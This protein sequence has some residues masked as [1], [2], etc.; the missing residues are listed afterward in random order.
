MGDGRSE[1][2][3]GTHKARR[4][5]RDGWTVAR[6][7][8]FLD[9]LAQ[10]ANVEASARAVGLSEH[11][12]YMLRRRDPVFADAW[13]MAL[14][15]GYDRIEAA[16]IRKAMGEPD[17]AAASAAPG[18]VAPGGGI[19]L[20]LAMQLLSRHKPAV[21]RNA[22]AVRAQTIRAGR[23]TAADALARKLDALARR[24][25]RDAAKPIASDAREG[26]A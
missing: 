21:E 24:V 8:A 4:P 2:G 18:V 14:M 9:H 23:A 3:A 11:S 6:R 10:T 7:D 17:A 12:A 19:D 16:L 22:K 25:A 5:R 1:Q 13:H 26:G 20:L 15:T